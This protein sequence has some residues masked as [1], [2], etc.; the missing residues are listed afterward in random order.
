MCHC[1]CWW[2]I[3]SLS[4]PLWDWEIKD[5]RLIQKWGKTEV[6]TGPYK[7]WFYQKGIFMAERLRLQPKRGVIS[8]SLLHRAYSLLW[9]LIPHF[10][11]FFFSWMETFNSSDILTLK[12]IVFLNCNEDQ[13]LM[14]FYPTKNAW[15]SSLNYHILN[16]VIW[17]EFFVPRRENH[18]N[19][20][21]GYF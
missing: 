8:I 10:P 7:T 12:H 13:W 14:D 2:Y 11:G 4:F 3:I 20:C 9:C 16:I 1:I 21:F 19:L 17:Q 5:M 15:F 6:S 18:C